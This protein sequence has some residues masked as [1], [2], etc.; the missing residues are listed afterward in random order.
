MGL[1]F[2]DPARWRRAS[3]PPGTALRWNYV[4]PIPR[5]SGYYC[6]CPF[7]WFADFIDS[8][9][10]RPVQFRALYEFVDLHL[11]GEPYPGGPCNRKFSTITEDS[12]QKFQAPKDIFLYGRGGAKE[13][14]Y[15]LLLY[16]SALHI[17]C[18][19]NFRF[20]ILIISFLLYYKNAVV[21]PR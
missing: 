5:R 12:P 4:Y 17:T 10:S 9:N 13:L 6:D 15:V 2:R 16:S 3:C 8:N 11:D 19:T 7:Y 18:F 14:R 21:F 1:A 20:V